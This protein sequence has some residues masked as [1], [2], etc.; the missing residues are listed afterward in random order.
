MKATMIN[1]TE[2]ARVSDRRMILIGV[3]V[4]YQDRKKTE[5]V[6]YG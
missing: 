3:G 4:G 1:S 5:N 6:S 2:W